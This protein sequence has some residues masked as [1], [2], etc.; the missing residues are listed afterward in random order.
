KPNQRVGEESGTQGG[1][2]SVSRKREARNYAKEE[3]NYANLYTPL[4]YSW[5][6]GTI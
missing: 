3:L 4:S 5:D 1:E 6:K 2:T